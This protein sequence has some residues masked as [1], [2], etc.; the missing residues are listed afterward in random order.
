MRSDPAIRELFLMPKA[1]YSLA[2]SAAIL[3][4]SEAD[5]RRC[6][7]V[8]EIEGLPAGRLLLIEWA[9]L[10]SFGID[11]WS[12]ELVENAVGSE[13][14]QA[15]PELVRLTGLEVRIPRLHAVA[16]AHVAAR[17]GRSVSTVVVSL[18]RDFVSAH[19]EWL[20]LEVPGFADA[21]AWPHGASAIE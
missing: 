18:L 6:I 5:L 2:E 19:S 11:L 13:I 1:A 3:G 17:D 21:L 14:A 16:L 12:Q 20:A 9:E 7:A 8:D 15:I 4:M 10:V